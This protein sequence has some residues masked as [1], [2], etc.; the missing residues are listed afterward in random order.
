MIHD[1]DVKNSKF[2]NIIYDKKVKVILGDVFNES[3][4]ILHFDEFY[5]RLKTKI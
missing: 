2:Y 1:K 4:P 3:F 5:V